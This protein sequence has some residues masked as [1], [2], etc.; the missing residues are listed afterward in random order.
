MH[1][2]SATEEH[3]QDAV[4]T[5]ATETSASPTK[6][7]YHNV[8]LGSL[9]SVISLSEELRDSLPRL[10]I[11]YLIAGIGVA[12]YGETKD[13]L[14]NH[15]GV[16]NLSQLAMTDVILPKMLETAKGKMGEERYSTRIVAEASELHRTAPSDFKAESLA[17]MCTGEPGPNALYGRSKL[18]K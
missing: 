6:L 17:E 18:C 12:P 8:D 13:G 15:F 7:H 3:G 1:I 16:N 14:G 9:K 10:D 5:I 4:Q 2:V 11:L